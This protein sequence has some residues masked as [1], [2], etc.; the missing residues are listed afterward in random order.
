M[1]YCNGICKKHKHTRKPREKWYVP[2]V[3]RCNFCNIFMKT[4]SRDCICC[5]TTLRTQGRGS[6]VKSTRVLKRM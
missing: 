3:K 1:P 6:D 4:I 2:G 5:K